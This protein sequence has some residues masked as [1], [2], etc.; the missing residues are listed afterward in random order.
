MAVL[1]I[2]GFIAIGIGFIE[3]IW[4][5]VVVAATPEVSYFLVGSLA[6]GFA[7]ICYLLTFF[8]AV[9]F[10]IGLLYAYVTAKRG[11]WYKAMWIG[12]ICGFFLLFLG[13][14]GFFGGLCGLGGAAL[15]YLDPN[16]RD[17]GRPGYQYQAPPPPPPQQP[18]PQAPPPRCEKPR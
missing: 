15:I 12:A 18:P 10:A 9:V 2:G 13:I 11:N 17:L 1:V 16:L 4:R 14:G 5:I 8:L 3:M 6:A 7:I